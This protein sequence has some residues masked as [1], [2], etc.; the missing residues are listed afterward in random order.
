MVIFFT[1][2]P[3]SIKWPWILVNQFNVFGE[4]VEISWNANGNRIMIKTDSYG[5]RY[6]LTHRSYIELV[7]LDSG[8]ERLFRRP[9][10]AIDYPPEYEKIWLRNTEKLIKIFGKDKVIV[11]IPDY[12][13]D[14]VNVWGREHALWKD[15]KDNI[16]RT[17]ENIIYYWDKYCTNLGIRCLI[18]VQGYYNNPSSI[19]KSVKLLHKYGLVKEGEIFGIANLCT[20]KRTYVIVEEVRIAR[21][22]LC[23]KWIH[24]FGPSLKSVKDLSRYVDSFDTAVP[25]S[26]RRLWL[27]AYMKTDYENVKY[28]RSSDVERLLFTKALEIAT[29]K[30]RTNFRCD[31]KN[32]YLCIDEAI[33]VFRSTNNKINVFTC[34]D[35]W[36][37]K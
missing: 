10:P 28:I 4:A 29:K 3:I 12:P 35:K 34:L 11:T 19:S 24:V 13:D 9:E 15:G 32:I 22:L 18:P 31:D 1:I 26:N 17:I 23:D 2:P 27:A 16:E 7:L 6:L 33:S 14:Y 20:T 8:V 25:N 5:L 37:K 36:I 30:L 21:N